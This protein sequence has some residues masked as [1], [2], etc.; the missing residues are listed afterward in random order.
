MSRRRGRRVNNMPSS[1]RLRILHLEDD[2]ADA[3]LIERALEEEGITAQELVHVSSREAFVKALAGGPFDLILSDYSLPGFDGLTALA[4]VR[5]ASVETPFVLVTGTIGED[6]AAE[7]IK[8]GATDFVLK[9]RLTRL[10]IAIRRALDEV[11]ERA[12]R[13]LLE[14]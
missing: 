10:G 12:E 13:K 1:K 6:R 4:M 14:A 9:D 7:T 8:S 2:P 11:R 5:A 3:M